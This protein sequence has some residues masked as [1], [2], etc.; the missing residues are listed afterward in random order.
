MEPWIVLI[1][2]VAGLLVFGKVLGRLGLGWGPKKECGWTPPAK[3]KDQ[4][5]RP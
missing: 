2:L 5:K 3:D 4:E 1:L